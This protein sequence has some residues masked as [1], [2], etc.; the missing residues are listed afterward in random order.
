MA[1]TSVQSMTTGD[2]VETLS[3]TSEVTDQS[4]TK[5]PI[6]HGWFAPLSTTEEIRR[7][8]HTDVSM[9]PRNN[10]WGLYATA[11][12]AECTA[13]PS[14]IPDWVLPHAETHILFDAGHGL[15]PDLIYARGVPNTP[16]LDPTFFNKMQCTLIIIEIGFCRDLGCHIKFD[17]KTE[18]YSPLIAALRKYWGRVEFVAFRYC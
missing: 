18:K 6:P 12:D 15:A 5:K 16:S 10:H 17:E 11:G 8:R 14:R 13:A 1:D 2:S 9:D 7:K 3:P 4:P